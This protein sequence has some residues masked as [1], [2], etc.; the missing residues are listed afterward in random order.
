MS[1]RLSYSE[2][3]GI[4]GPS[5]FD[6][7]LSDLF[8]Q[9]G[10]S[11]FIVIQSEFDRL[12]ALSNVPGSILMAAKQSGCVSFTVNNYGSDI[13]ILLIAAGGQADLLQQSNRYPG[14]FPSEK[15]RAEADATNIH[16]KCTCPFLM[17]GCTCGYVAERKKN[18]Q[19]W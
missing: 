6:G 18:G 4:M 17:G 7:A 13:N 9:Y 15:A 2:T 16:A 5:D 3:S 12:L 19:S 10:D 8:V 14:A 11:D 1:V